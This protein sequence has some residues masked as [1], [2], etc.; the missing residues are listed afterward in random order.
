M[1]KLQLR[2]EFFFENVSPV[3]FFVFTASF[4]GLIFILITPPFQTPDETV[5][6]YRSY[7]V[8]QGN[9]VIDQVGNTFGGFLPK[10]LGTTVAET[11][12]N[13]TLE[14]R[15][16]VKYEKAKTRAAFSIREDRGDKILYDF[17]ATAAYSPISYMPQSLGVSI[18]K[19]FHTPPIMMMYFGRLMNLSAWIILLAFSIKLIPYKKWA[20]VGVALLPMALFDAISLGADTMAYGL[21]ALLLSLILK[22]TAD[23]K[24]ITNNG[25]LMLMAVLS[26]LVITKQV[27]FIFVAF[28]LILPTVLFGRKPTSYIKKSMLIILPLTVFGIWMTT[29][30]NLSIPVI[31][32]FDP[33]PSLQIKSIIHNPLEYINVLWN[34]YFFINSD[35]IARSFIGTFGWMD[36]PVSEFIS[37]TGY[38]TLAFLLIANYKK[39]INRLMGKQRLILVTAIVVY[40]LAVTT[41]LYAY[42]GPVNH[43]VVIGIQGRYFIPVA[44]LLIPLLYNNWL[45]TSKI[46]Y[47]KFATVLPTLLLVASVITIFYRYYVEL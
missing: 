12:S 30:S 19:L 3:R 18:A 33:D 34:T 41:A 46:N 45:R 35:G 22:F 27:M 7:Q 39:P 21:L 10:S 47:K 1:K 32:P 20:V 16:D 24:P 23:R 36:A 37:V 2:L 4:F 44:L 38:T 17:S 8:A 31:S 26:C 13:H 40:W 25:Y 9:F 14:F 43:K 42:Y 11:T 28:V 15:P 6:Y 5:H 29:I